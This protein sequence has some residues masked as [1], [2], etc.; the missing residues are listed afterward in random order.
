MAIEIRKPTAFT[1]LVGYTNPGQ[2]IDVATGDDRTT[3]ATRTPRR[4]EL[5]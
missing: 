2:A 5:G 1:D 4:R 3:A